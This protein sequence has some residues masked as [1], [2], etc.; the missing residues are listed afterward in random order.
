MLRLLFS[1]IFFSCSL[2]GLA[3]KTIQDV[4]FYSYN[5]QINSNKTPIDS[6]NINTPSLNNNEWTDYQVGITTPFNDHILKESYWN[7]KNQLWYNTTII[8]IK[9]TD[10]VIL[11]F[12]DFYIPNTGKLYINGVHSKQLLKYDSESNMD[13]G[14]FSTS[15]I[16]D[17]EIKITY[18][19]SDKNF[20]PVVDLT[21]IGVL[22]TSQK[23]PHSFS[24]RDKKGG[25]NQSGKCQINANCSEGKFVKNEKRSVLRLFTKITDKIFECTG[26][27]MNNTNNDFTPYVLTA[28]HCANLA[29]TETYSSAEDLEQWIFEFNYESAT[30]DNPPNENDIT[31]QS[32]VGA[33]LKAQS[34]DMGGNNGSDFFLVEINSPI[35]ENYEAFFAGWNREDTPAESGTSIHHP[36][37]DLKKISTFSEK[38]ISSSSISGIP[39]TYWQLQWSETENGKSVTEAGSSGGPL[40]DQ[41]NFYVGGLNGGSASCENLDGF[42]WYGKLA[43]SW[44]SNGTTTNRQLKPHL[45]PNNSGVLSL[46]GIGFYS[47]KTPPTISIE[48]STNEVCDSTTI[49]FTIVKQ[50]NQGDHP[51]YEWL[52]NNKVISTGTSFSSNNLKNKD[53]VKARLYSSVPIEEYITISNSI[54]MDLTPTYDTKISIK[55]ITSEIC[56]GNTTFIEIDNQTGQGTYEWFVNNISSGTTDS[57]TSDTLKTDDTIKLIL[58]STEKCRTKDVAISNNIIMT[59]EDVIIPSITINLINQSFPICDDETATFEA[60]TTG[61]GNSPT[62]EWFKNNSPQGIGWDISLDSLQNDDNIQALLSSSLSC[63]AT[64]ITASNNITVSTV[65]C[66]TGFS[67]PNDNYKVELFPNPFDN[68]I[69]LSEAVSKVII[70]NSLGNLILEVSNTDQINTDQLPQGIYLI[71]IETKQGLQT[72]QL[73]KR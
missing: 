51:Y 43:Y 72:N 62:I 5:Q 45:D 30:C 67:S 34:F 29:N 22:N 32:L 36:N 60:T 11:Y 20:P 47:N 16:Y 56:T 18:Q 39:D 70:R 26:T 15:V 50:S 48:N 44:E 68:Q 37:H 12:K 35:P 24:V 57:F 9:N 65:D 64:T 10:G 2:L 41:N 31:S 8:N 66:T 13:L 33:T 7:Y 59:V 46:K 4:E 6:I 1:I 58:T 19:T 17:N 73:I 53:T 23:T 63:A 25:F 21:E 42:D 52:V 28:E 3:Q 69:Q 40:F 61:S 38:V 49:L 71:T 27:L 14:A 54:I 55:S